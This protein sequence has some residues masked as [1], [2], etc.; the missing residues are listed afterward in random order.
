MVVLA[1]DSAGDLYV[2]D[3]EAVYEFESSGKFL[4][5]ITEAEGVP[6]GA[7][8]AV[9]IDPA[10]G[11][12]LIA[13]GGAIDEFSSTGTYLDDIEG[14]GVARDMA[15]ESTGKLYVAVGSVVDVFG[16]YTP[17]PP[18]APVIENGAA[19]N[20]TN[21]FFHAQRDREAQ[22]RGEVS[23]CRFEYGNSE[24]YGRS[25][26]CSPATLSGT[27]VSGA[28]S[29]LQPG[30]L[31]YYR[32]H[33]VDPVTGPGG[34]FGPVDAVRT[35]APNPIVAGPP[36][37]NCPN[38]GHSGLSDRLPDCR[39]DPLPTPVNLGD[40]KDMFGD[41][42]EESPGGGD[43]YDTGYPEEEP[44]EEGDKF[45][46]TAGASAFGPYASA[47]NNEYVFSRSPGGWQETSLASHA[48]G[49]QSITAGYTILS[50]DFSD[51]AI[52]DKIGSTGNEASYREA[53]LVGPVGEPEPYTALYESS[54]YAS[55]GSE[56]VGASAN[57]DRIFFQSTEHQYAGAAEGQLAGSQALYEHSG[58]R[59]TL[60]NVKSDGE[61]TSEC[62]AV[63]PAGENGVGTGAHAVSTDGSRVFFLSPDPYD[64]SCFS[65]GDGSLGEPSEFSGTPPQLYMRS[66]GRTIWVSEP[67]KGVT[68]PDGEQIVAFAGASADGSRVFFVTRGEL[69]KDDEGNHDPELYEYDLETETL[70]RISSGDT[71]NAEGNVGWVVPSED[72]STVYFTATGSLA[73]GA[74]TLHAIEGSARESQQYNLYH[75]DTETA[76]TTFIATVS[77]HD[78]TRSET[79]GTVTLNIKQPIN[80]RSDWETTPDGRYLLLDAAEDL[81]GYDSHDPTEH[82]TGAIPGDG[83]GEGHN[84][85]E[86][87]RY[88]AADGSLICVSCDPGGAAPHANALFDQNTSSHLVRAISDNGA[89][90]FFDTSEKELVPTA[91]N[92][93]RNVYEWHE[94]AISLISSGQDANNSYFLGTDASGADVFFGSH[95]RL[96]PQ[97]TDTSGNLYDARIDGGFPVSQG[98]AACE[99][100]DDSD[101]CQSPALPPSEV[102]PFSLTFSGPGNL[103]SKSSLVVPV[104]VPV[105]GTKCKRGFTKKKGKCVKNK[106]AKRAKKA[107][108]SA[109]TGRRASR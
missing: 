26:P 100:E 31:Y 104:I 91:T 88:D 53:G 10:N 42:S 77:G 29:G 21:E 36:A 13:A 30:S 47:G 32:V 34:A 51:A 54:G 70:T 80:D 63:S 27:A 48:G 106:K 62:G 99:S 89:Y 35:F 46:L 25:A 105:P 107:K 102:S 4:R 33:V 103:P 2:A 18:Q 11:H 17:P 64:G 93:L 44:S 101:A 95:A 15:V 52:E 43:S 58:G 5:A 56:L 78:W 50:S 94:G 96:V 74:P 14:V 79:A 86:V 71:H 98:A 76:S 45:L 20:I 12:V 90:V 9:A 87:Y 73:P 40:S 49:V 81:T 85:E 92:G 23:E 7:V 24:S 55:N 22:G 72:G 8:S 68:D 84:C 109:R 38:P 60:V 6:L 41:A 69:T 97:D 19:S 61:L 67:E 1:V 75:Y 65:E 39:G 16:T 59:D 57:F 28:L 83:G 108:T 37:S 66:G 3:G 82:C